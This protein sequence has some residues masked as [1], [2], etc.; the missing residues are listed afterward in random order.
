MIEMTNA[1]KKT[2][3]NHAIAVD[4]AGTKFIEGAFNFEF[5]ND[6]DLQVSAYLPDCYKYF[7]KNHKLEKF[8]NE[9]LIDYSHIKSFAFEKKRNKA[10]IEIQF[11]ITKEGNIYDIKT[12]QFVDV[13]ID[14]AY[15]NQEFLELR[16]TDST[17]N[18]FLEYSKKAFIKNIGEYKDSNEYGDVILAPFEYLVKLALTKYSNQEK[19]PLIEKTNTNIIKKEAPI[20]FHS[21]KPACIY[22]LFNI[23]SL[24]A[25]LNKNTEILKAFEKSRDQFQ[26]AIIKAENHKHLNIRL[27]DRFYGGKGLQKP[28]IHTELNSDNNK[29]TLSDSNIFNDFLKIEQ[30]ENKYNFLSNQLEEYLLSNLSDITKAI[31]LIAENKDDISNNLEKFKISIKNL[32]REK[33][34]YSEIIFNSLLDSLPEV[35]FFSYGKKINFEKNGDINIKSVLKLSAQERNLLIENLLSNNQE[36]ADSLFCPFLQKFNNSNIDFGENL[37]VKVKKKNQKNFNKALDDKNQTPSTEIE[38][39]DK[40]QLSQIEKNLVRIKHI[41]P[42]FFKQ[43]NEIILMIDDGKEKEKSS[44]EI[45]LNIAKSLGYN[46]N[47]TVKVKIDSCKYFLN[48]NYNKKIASEAVEDTSPTL[49]TIKIDVDKFIPEDFNKHINKAYD[50]LLDR[51]IELQLE[52]S[53]KIERQAFYNFKNSIMVFSNNPNDDYLSR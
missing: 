21:F 50:K 31:F 26:Q 43:K 39:V 4:A 48:F 41:Y 46:L 40:S 38:V 8:L 13:K 18:T 27:L 2:L 19:L 5:L 6:G 15:N 49:F 25:H 42:E 14:K 34:Q 7:D 37:E 3:R 1:P 9:Y 22:G 32:L 16:K 23:Y 52:N 44:K 17:I 20:S 51:I 33:S 24:L 11:K 47:E 28:S 29:N 30:N 12:P 45:I 10:G 36:S 53:E 35:S